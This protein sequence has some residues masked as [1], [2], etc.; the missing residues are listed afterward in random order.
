MPGGL[1]SQTFQPSK[2]QVESSRDFRH[3]RYSYGHVKCW[4]K[5]CCTPTCCPFPQ[6][7]I[8]TTT[9]VTPSILLRLHFSCNNTAWGQ[10]CA[11]CRG[12]CLFASH[13][14][15]SESKMGTYD[16]VGFGSHSSIFVVRNYSDLISGIFRICSGLWADGLFYWTRFIR[17]EVQ[18]LGRQE[19]DKCP[20]QLS[21]LS[22]RWNTISIILQL[23]IKPNS[24]VRTI[25]H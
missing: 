16:W 22:E 7:N 3:H 9:S 6:W 15:N 17:Q 8:D 14:P 18:T 5:H 13:N 11:F 23:F 25:R 1:E 24:C 21:H 12:L 20:L 4:D 10:D 19:N 2:S